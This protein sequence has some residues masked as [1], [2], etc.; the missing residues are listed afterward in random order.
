MSSSWRISPTRQIYTRC[1]RPHAHGPPL[2]VT[3][4]LISCWCSASTMTLETPLGRKLDPPCM[5]P[6]LLLEAVLTLRW[7]K[8]SRPTGEPAPL[9]HAS[10]F[11]QWLYKITHSELC[12]KKWMF[13]LSYSKPMLQKNHVG[14]AWRNNWPTTFYQTNTGKIPYNAA[15]IGK[16][17]N[18]TKGKITC[19]EVYLVW[20][21]GLQ[22]VVVLFTNWSK[23]F[24]HI[25][26]LIHISLEY[27]G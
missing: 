25:A 27:A 10:Y 2:L 20:K 15:W 21:P 23:L 1:S 5:M 11:A 16:A 26:E 6:S 7:K 18:K 12:S 4:S 3:T 14:A 9:K 19:F 22:W 17:Q 8:A 13:W 24:N